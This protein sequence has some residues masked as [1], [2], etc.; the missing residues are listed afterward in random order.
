MAVLAVA[1]REGDREQALLARLGEPAG[2][3]EQ[4]P[5]KQPA[6][7]PDA[8][9]PGLLNDGEVARSRHTDHVD[10]LVE[11]GHQRPKGDAACRRRWRGGRRRCAGGPAAPT[12]CRGEQER[13]QEPGAGHAVELRA[14][15][16]PGSPTGY[17]RPS[18]PR[19]GSQGEGV[20]GRP[21][22]SR[23]RLEDQI[24]RRLGHAAEAREAS[25]GPRPSR[26]RAS[27]ACAPS[28][29]PTS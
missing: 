2:E 14:T 29:S 23:P 26:I 22:P 8:H 3:V 9:Q 10:R 6:V 21:Q 15:S 24:E 27:P 12:A 17:G 7:V 1:G 18:P 16:W 4:W 19:P 20:G 25:R 11:A 5:R 28:A 13:Q